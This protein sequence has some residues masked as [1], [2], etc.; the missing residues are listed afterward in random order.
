L[1]EVRR[2]IDPQRGGR[3]MGISIVLAK[4]RVIFIG[5]TNITELPDADDLMQIAMQA[6]RTA[7]RFGVEPKVAF[8][9]YST[10]GNPPGERMEKVRDAVAQLSRREDIDFEFDGEM[11][12]DVA[13]DP[14]ARLLYPFSR[15]SEP[16]NVLIM[17][18]IHS[19]SISTK[20]LA[21]LG[22]ATVIGPLLCGLDQSVQIAPLNAPVSDIV[23]FATMAAYNISPR[24]VR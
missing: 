15:L 4:G 14:D 23:T 9:S 24:P 6:A 3:L 8:T 21:T 13:L 19:A 18:A 20:L 1:E 12:P 22:G 16:A 2:V 7:R 11:S 10:F 17:P 5:D